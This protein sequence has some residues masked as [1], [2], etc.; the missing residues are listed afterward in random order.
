MNERIDLNPVAFVIGIVARGLYLWL[1]VP[2]GALAG[3]IAYP[4][5]R[6]RDASIGQLIGWLDLNAFAA[7]FHSVLRPFRNS[8]QVPWVPLKDLSTV[9]HRVR[10]F[11][12][13]ERPKGDPDLRNDFGMK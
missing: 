3:T 11:D 1:L 12:D 2:L 8:T 10:I 6:K 7:V 13:P 9:K 5:L 4:L